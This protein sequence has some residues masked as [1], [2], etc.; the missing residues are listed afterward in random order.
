MEEKINK[1][2]KELSTIQIR[3]ENL[4]KELFLNENIIKQLNA[5]LE[6]LIECSK[7]EKNAQ[8]ID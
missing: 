5:E 1:I 4:K 3:N 7:T 2:M 8:N 6:E